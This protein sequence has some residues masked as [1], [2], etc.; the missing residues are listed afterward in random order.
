[1]VS[2]GFFLKQ[3]CDDPSYQVFLRKES[4]LTDL[5]AKLESKGKVLIYKSM[6]FFD[7][8]NVRITLS[9]RGRILIHTHMNEFDTRSFLTSLL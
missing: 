5:K 7:D 8:G 6:M 2:D 3:L 9:D 4:S 1:M